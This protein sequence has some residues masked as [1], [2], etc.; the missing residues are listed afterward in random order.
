L[1]LTLRSKTE[2]HS[3]VYHLTATISP[4]SSGSSSASEVTVSS[5]FNKWFTSDGVFAAKP[6][7]QWLASAIPVVGE[8]DPNNI[9]EEIGRGSEAES[10]Q[11][12]INLED[13]MQHISSGKAG[14]TGKA[15]KR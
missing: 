11:G 7:Q 13:V 4:A 12:G 5:P 9:V 15:R 10:S 6:F 14:K 8:A 1:Q 2:K 3:P